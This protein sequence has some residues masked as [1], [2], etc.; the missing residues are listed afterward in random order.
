MALPMRG[1]RHTLEKVNTMFENICK[2][3]GVLIT[4]D[5]GVMEAWLAIWLK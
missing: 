1:F 5:N 3:K 2:N 4:G